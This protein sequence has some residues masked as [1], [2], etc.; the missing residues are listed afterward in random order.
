MKSL[1]H[2]VTIIALVCMHFTYAQET[3]TPPPT[4]DTPHGSGSSTYKSRS[5]SNG[6]SS[7]HSIS[8]KNDNLSYRFRAS[9]SKKLSAKIHTYLMKELGDRNIDHSKTTSFWKIEK[10]DETAFSCKLNKGSLK[11]YMDKEAFSEKFQQQILNMGEQ[12]KYMISGRDPMEMKK[13]DLE[14]ARRRLKQ[15]EKA[16]KRAEKR[17]NNY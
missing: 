7:S 13:R 11:I 2:I 5:R 14:R 9:F 15:A 10:N 4:P 6:S 12:L 17:A 16:L 8:V 3:P 1:K